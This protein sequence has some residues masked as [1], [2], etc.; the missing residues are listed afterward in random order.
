MKTVIAIFFILFFL[1]CSDQGEVYVNDKKIFNTPIKC[2]QLS[3]FPPNK[4]MESTLKSLYQFDTNCSYELALS[5][6]TDIV[7]NSNQ[8]WA[9]KTS[10]IPNGYIRIEIKK[11]GVLLYTYYKDLKGPLTDDKLIEG[12]NRLQDDLNLL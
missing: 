9:Q 1:G 3:I 7:C 2:M 11:E 4:E 12:F 10:G 6:K 8:N 5:Y